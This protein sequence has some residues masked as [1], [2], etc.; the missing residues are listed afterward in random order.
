MKLYRNY[1]DVRTLVLGEKGNLVEVYYTAEEFMGAC[2]DP[3]YEEIDID[4]IIWY[5]KGL[6]RG[7]PLRMTA[8]MSE[9]LWKRYGDFDAVPSDEWTTVSTFRPENPRKESPAVTLSIK[10]EPDKDPFA[11]SL[12]EICSREAYRL[13]GVVA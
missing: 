12:K 3:S 8:A 6:K 10:K 7:Q 1:S 9:K 4:E 2:D 11:E 13:L 5:G